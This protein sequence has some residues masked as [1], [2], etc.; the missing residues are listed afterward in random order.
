MFKL[1]HKIMLMEHCTVGAVHIFA[2]AISKPLGGMLMVKVLQ[3][4]VSG[5]AVTIV[6]NVVIH[7]TTEC[8]DLYSMFSYSSWVLNDSRI[9]LLHLNVIISPYKH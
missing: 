5:L 7:L 9:Q 8:Y 1:V 3:P 4:L 2:I 6:E